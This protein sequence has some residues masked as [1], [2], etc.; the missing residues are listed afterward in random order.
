M[1]YDTPLGPVPEEYADLAALARTLSLS[2][3]HLDSPPDDLWPA[4]QRRVAAGEQARINRPLVAVDAT[5]SRFRSR[6]MYVAL[7][8]AAAIVAALIG[9]VAFV[10][11]DNGLPGTR[12]EEV[13]LT[14]KGLES[15]G[16]GSYATATLVRTANGS[17]ALDI[18]ASDLPSAPEGFLELWIID[19][20]ISGMYSLG[21]LHG[22]GR[23]VLPAHVD[24]ASFPIVD[25][26]IEPT[27]GTPAHSGKSILRGQ[28]TA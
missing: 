16:A 4:I 2:D 9:L 24:P 26:S 7:S 28:L 25:V 5:G 22:N 15:A 13:A 1:S 27:D 12:V 18:A 21:P 6:R 8:A 20:T 11:G 3:T 23:Y 19:K 10:S 14:N 17:Y